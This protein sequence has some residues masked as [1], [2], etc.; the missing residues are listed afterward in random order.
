[1]GF[2][3]TILFGSHSEHINIQIYEQR[4]YIPLIMYNIYLSPL[5]N[6]SLITAEPIRHNSV[7]PGKVYELGR[8]KCLYVTYSKNAPK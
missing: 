8:K 5:S 3:K 7:F 1:M 6:N 2:L 4:R